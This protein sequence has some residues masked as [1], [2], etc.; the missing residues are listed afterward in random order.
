M[1]WLFVFLAALFEMIGVMGVKKFSQQKT[2]TNMTLFVGGFALSFLFLYTS[3]HYLQVS[4]AY[5]VWIGVGT[6]GAVLLNMIF[7]G[8]FKS[9]ARF[10]CL[11]AIIIGVSGLKAVS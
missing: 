5:A 2:I 3:F 11:L 4:I 9:P 10:I 6:A 1:G 7:F 8:E